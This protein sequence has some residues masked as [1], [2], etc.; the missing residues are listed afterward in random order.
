MKIVFLILLG[1]LSTVN[2]FVV[3][4]EN[5]GKKSPVLSNLQGFDNRVG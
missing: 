2:T 1:L 3:K 4:Q 5:Q